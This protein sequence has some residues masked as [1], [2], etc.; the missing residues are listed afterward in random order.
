M[1]TVLI[2]ALAI[3]LAAIVNRQLGL[4]TMLTRAAA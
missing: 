1:E 3:A 2:V 4:D